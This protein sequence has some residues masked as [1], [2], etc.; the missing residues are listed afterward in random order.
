MAV[1]LPKIPGLDDALFGWFV[2]VGI[3]FIFAAFSG[4]WTLFLSKIL[5]GPFDVFFGDVFAG[6]PKLGPSSATDETAL[7]L[8]N[9]RNP[10]A[11]LW[12]LGVRGLE[13]KGIPTSTSNPALQDLYSNLREA[14]LKAFQKQF[15]TPGA[16][17]LA[18]QGL[19]FV[20]DG[21]R[22][23]G[24]LVMQYYNGLAFT[25]TNPLSTSWALSDRTKIDSYY[26][27][28][29]EQGWIDPNTGFPHTA[30]VQPPTPPT[31]I[32][33]PPPAPP[34][35][36]D[37]IEIYHWYKEQ[38][39]YHLAQCVCSIEAIL[40]QS[41]ASQQ[42]KDLMPALLQILTA[43]SGTLITFATA[44]AAGDAA[45]AAK[46]DLHPLAAALDKLVTVQAECC[47]VEAAGGA[48]LVAALDRIAAA[49]EKEKPVDLK[50]L[51]DALNQVGKILDV[52]PHVID[53]LVKQG[54]ISAEDAQVVQGADLG[55]WLITAFRTFGWTALVWGAKY[56][57]VDIT[58]KELHLNPLGETIAHVVEKFMDI[59]LDVG[60][61]PL[62]AVVAGALR[63]VLDQI[64]P[65]HAVAI[66]DAG[67][68][69]ELLLAKTLGPTLVVNA[70]AFVLSWFDAGGGEIMAK[71]VEAVAAFTGFEEVKEL[72]LGADMRAGPI[73]AARLNA[74]RTYRQALPAAP[75]LY[76]L[77]AMGL[78]TLDHAAH[79]NGYNGIPDELHGPLQQMAYRGIN[80]RIMLRLLDT[81]LF[82]D[83][84]IAEE[85]TFGAM[86][87]VSQHRMLVAAPYLA[88][89]PE[90]KQL[91][92]AFEK[93]YV[94]GYMSDAQLSDNLDAAEHNT[95]RVFLILDRVRMEKR[96][97][98]AKDLAESYRELYVG[99]LHNQATYQANLVGLG[100]QDDMIRAILAKAEARVA[101]TLAHQEAAA[102]RALARATALE[103]R[104]AA[105]R[106]YEQGAIE[107]AG[108]LAALLLTGLT[109]TQAAAWVDIAHLDK[110][111]K[112]KFAFGLRME[113][114][115][116][117][118]LQERVKALQDQR[119]RQLITDLEFAGV[120]KTLG[121]PPRY[122]NAL[123]AAADATLTPAKS[124]LVVPI[125]TG[126]S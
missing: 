105:L 115:Q 4:D 46:I 54:F 113:P 27:K 124:A 56:L 44:A 86:R 36:P 11:T 87:P 71:W 66:G 52:K 104:K 41:S 112:P 6:R 57:G 85:L 122:I 32:P 29:V 47:K 25:T 84:E 10:V 14:A 121:I 59:T 92:A 70:V 40:Q 16:P 79:L 20:A 117:Q 42:G 37:E 106:N 116:A 53:Y 63:G 61:V 24:L 1:E 80:P 5:L 67:V 77:A 94:D 15:D 21:T 69:D 100:L 58:G 73:A 45:I 19:P 26:L 33:P 8:A 28:L 119:K 108:L 43:I 72:Q 65:G 107:D 103:E 38:Y 13:A 109:A 96:I 31:T 88:T 75:T 68:D 3:D 99:G 51:V 95:S 118:L 81:G 34:D 111:G 89:D 83:A 55:D 62:Y 2:S 12:G 9:T 48:A 17:K 120:L 110:L 101:V 50:P 90:R 82:S 102:A 49:E 91:R 64:H 97:A 76:Q 18:T 93:A 125:D 35:S 7:F 60:A 39:E 30:P 126:T 22:V 123:R 114:P 98:V 78:M 74:Q 23:T